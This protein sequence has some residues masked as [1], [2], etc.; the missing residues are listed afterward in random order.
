[1]E[2]ARLRLLNNAAGK[3]ADYPYLPCFYGISRDFSIHILIY[4]TL[5]EK[6]SL[7]I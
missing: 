1:M 4:Q 6:Q 2:R 5:F 3:D 7:F